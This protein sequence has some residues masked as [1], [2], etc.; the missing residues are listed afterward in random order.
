MSLS[1]GEEVDADPEKVGGKELN[2]KKLRADFASVKKERDTLK[3]QLESS[4]N[5]EEV[6][7]L[8]QRVKDLEVYGIYSWSTQ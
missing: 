1:R 4:P 5:S 7:Q 8:R 6:E 3:K 2:F